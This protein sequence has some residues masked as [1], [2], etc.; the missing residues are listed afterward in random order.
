MTGKPCSPDEL[1]TL[2]LFEKLTDAQ[3]DWLCQRGRVEL[4]PAGPVYAEGDPA[5][6][7]YVLLE[8]TVVLSRRVGTD[9]V[10]VGRTSQRGA[11]AGAWQ[12]YLGDRVPQRYNSSMRATEPSR[13][14]V[15]D[16]DVFAELMNEWF[17]MAVD[18][19][20]VV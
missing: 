14:F 1:R 13:F 6:C 4:V 8:G 17:P 11:Y 20:S 7:F 2:F 18:R 12:A 5:R 16:A 10:E 19:K 9:D 3:L 15:L